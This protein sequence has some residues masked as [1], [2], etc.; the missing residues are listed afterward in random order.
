MDTLRLIC[1]YGGW[2]YYIACSVISWVEMTFSKR[3][4]PIETTVDGVV[5]LVA[6]PLVGMAV[7]VVIPMAAVHMLIE[8]ERE[9]AE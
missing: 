1:D 5:A 2:S 8:W 7:M 3:K 9:R 6:A 4:G